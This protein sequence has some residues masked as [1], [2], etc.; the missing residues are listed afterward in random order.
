[1]NVIGMKPQEW[2]DYSKEA[3]LLCFNEIKAV[4]MDRISFALLAVDEEKPVAYM[5]IQELDGMTA[6]LQHGGSFPETRGS[7]NSWKAYVSML[8]YL[9]EMGYVRGGTYIENT[10]KPMLKFAMKAG[11]L[12]TGIRTFEGT[13]LL[14]HQIKFEELEA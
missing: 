4:D 6:Y 3:H 2:A 9:K 8:K 10:N 7:A 5:T 12:I 14:E 13:V 11:W 1:M